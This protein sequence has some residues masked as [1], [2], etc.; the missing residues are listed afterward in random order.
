MRVVS[1]FLCAVVMHEDEVEHE[2]LREVFTHVTFSIPHRSVV[3]LIWKDEG[4]FLM[5]HIASVQTIQENDTIRTFS[6]TIAT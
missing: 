2:E 4:D 6:S 3:P 5:I 1:L